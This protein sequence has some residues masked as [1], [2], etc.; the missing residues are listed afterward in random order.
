MA[1]ATRFDYLSILHLR[2]MKPSHAGY[3]LGFKPH[4]DINKA[5]GIEL[6]SIRQRPTPMMF[7]NLPV[8]LLAQI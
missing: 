1:A 2:V 3:R 6:S 4:I 5:R 8:E 7:S